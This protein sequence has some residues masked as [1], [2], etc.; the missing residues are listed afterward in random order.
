MK[1]CYQ[2]D[3]G[4]IDREIVRPRVDRLPFA[5]EA[6]SAEDTE[7]ATHC[8]SGDV[9]LAMEF[10]CSMFT[11]KIPG[12]ERNN[13]G[14]RGNWTYYSRDQGIIYVVPSG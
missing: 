4:H 1:S 2:D 7:C 14:G 3:D 9:A 6:I 13:P 8:F 11:S 10:R 12:I 5:I